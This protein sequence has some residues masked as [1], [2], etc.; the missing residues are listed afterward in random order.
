G[1]PESVGGSFD[2]SNY[3][4]HISLEGALES[5]GGNSD[6]S[7]NGLISLEGAPESVGGNFDCSNN[8]F[9]SLEGA[10][11]ENKP[12]FYNFLKKGLI[13]CDGILTKKISIKIKQDITIYKTAKLGFKKNAPIIYVAQ[14]DEHFAHGE[15]IKEAFAELQFKTADRDVSKYENMPLT[16]KKTPEEWAIVYR[17]ITGACQVG[18]KMFMEGLGEL[19][20]EYTL[21]EVINITTGA[22][23]STRFVEVVTE[24]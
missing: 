7:D 19:E 17:I 6:G 4:N 9:T 2:C 11:E 8:S 18:T 16:T 14:K 24:K 20:P 3:D 10:P 13:F 23:G 15:T 5:G 12:Q 1:A 22:Y 21:E